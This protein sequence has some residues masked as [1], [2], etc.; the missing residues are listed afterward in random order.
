MTPLAE[1]T[2]TSGDRAICMDCRGTGHR[3]AVC[4]GKGAV[5]PA[6]RGMRF[7]RT[8]Q[9][10][11]NEVERCTVCCEGN[12]VNDVLEMQAIR[13]YIARTQSAQEAQ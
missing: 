12:Q 6:C 1:K 5:C 10:V 9:T 11:G 2:L 4:G 3:C 13:R 8:A 7:R